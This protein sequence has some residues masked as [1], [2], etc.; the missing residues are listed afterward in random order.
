M[1]ASHN[2]P[3]YNGLKLFVN[4][5]E[6]YTEEYEQLKVLYKETD[7]SGNEEN[8]NVGNEDIRIDKEMR[9]AFLEK[10]MS[11]L[12]ESGPAVFDLAGGAVCAI[13]EVFMTRI[14]DTPDPTFSRHSPEPAP[15]G[16]NYL[17]NLSRRNNKLGIAFDG[18]GDRVVVIDK[19]VILS[20]VLGTF[21]L[22][23]DLVYARNVV[24]TVDCSSKVF[25]RLDEQGYNPTYS[26][27]GS[28]NVIKN[29]MRLPNSYGFEDSG[30]YYCQEENISLMDQ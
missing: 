17:V 13:K 16:L 23:H 15:E 8:S 12:P 2:P 6:M 22:E 18:D 7:N 19:E 11:S 26:A 5:C 9:T 25:R 1:T 3:E 28:V 10:Y 27:V 29:M 20:D 4:G 24:M 14:F 21:L 30:R